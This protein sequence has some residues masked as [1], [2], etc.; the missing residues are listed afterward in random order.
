LGADGTGKP[1]A[2][3]AAM[4]AWRASYHALERQG[5][6]IVEIDLPEM[7]TLRAATGVILSV[8]AAVCH[9]AGL[10]THYHDFGDPCRVRL[11]GG[12][13]YA[14]TD[15]VL[16]QRIRRAVRRRWSAH[17]DRIDVLSMPSQPDVAPPL[18][19]PAS[20]KFTSPFNALGWPAI[21][22]PSAT[23]PGG[24]PLA[25]QIV[26][27]PWDE[28]GVLRVARALERVR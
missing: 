19:E 28:A 1:L 25:T 24:L 9:A 8:E 21:S 7:S 17:F 20:T 3:D 4:A 22:V 6:Q 18:G 23:G 27:R 15:L 12:F 16:A 14:A 13:V 5:A 26:G 11:L 2:E 10:R